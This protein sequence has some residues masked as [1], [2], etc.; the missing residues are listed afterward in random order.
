MS[1]LLDMYFTKNPIALKT[2]KLLPLCTFI[3]VLIPESC[4]V[5][6]EVGGQMVMIE[7]GEKI[8]GRIY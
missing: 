7:M 3:H 6:R 5:Q 1:Q 4:P 8:S 2:D